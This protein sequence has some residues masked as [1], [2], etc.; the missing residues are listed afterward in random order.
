MLYIVKH[1]G[2]CLLKGFNT[3]HVTRTAPAK[4]HVRSSAFPFA[5]N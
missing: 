3:I 5:N 4:V 1:I 2:K